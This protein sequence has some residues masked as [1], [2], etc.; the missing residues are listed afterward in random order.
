MYFNS[1]AF[2]RPQEK[3]VASNAR[4]WPEEAAA[5]QRRLADLAAGAG[6]SAV[7]PTHPGAAGGAR[8]RSR[9]RSMS[10]DW[11]SRRRSRSKSR[12]RS[13][14]GTKDWGSRGRSGQRG[15][16]TRR[17]SRSRSRGRSRGSALKQEQEGK[18]RHQ[19]SPSRSGSPSWASRRRRQRERQYGGSRSRSGSRAGMQ[20]QLGD[21]GPALRE[22][23][24]QLMATPHRQHGPGPQAPQPQPLTSGMGP[25]LGPPPVPAACEPCLVPVLLKHKPGLQEWVLSGNIL[26]VG[27]LLPD[28]AA[29]QLAADL[30]AS[31]EQAGGTGGPGA[32]LL[33]GGTGSA[34]CVLWEASRA[35][36]FSPQ[37]DLLGHAPFAPPQAR[38]VSRA[39]GQAGVRLDSGVNIPT[40]ARRRT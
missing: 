32:L 16:C 17:H 9:S 11:N 23:V 19:R 36:S 18:R 37:P 34:C 26:Y 21:G 13:R 25:G 14:G 28:L 27:G 30:R 29:E 15:R 10:G 33:T 6:A 1:R 35:A 7:Q 39:C 20:A 40:Q 4:A 22:G 24:N 5:A 38:W 12:S 2:L 3:A 8:R 31:A